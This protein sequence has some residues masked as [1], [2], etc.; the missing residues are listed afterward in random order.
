MNKPP[1]AWKNI[2]CLSLL[3]ATAKIGAQELSILGG[4]MTATQLEQSS[5]TW[6]VDYRQDFYRGLAGSVTYINEGHVDGHHRDGTAWQAWARLPFSHDRYALA[7]GAGIYYYYDT[8]MIAGESANVHGTAPIYGATFTGYFSDRWFYRL[9]AER[10]TPSH[11][12]KTTLAAAGAG[13]WFGRDRRPVGGKLGD[14]PAEKYYVTPPELTFFGGQSVVNTFF[15]EQAKAAALEFRRGLIPHVDWSLSGIYEGNP[16]V[17]RRNG[18][19]PQLWGVNTFYAERVSVGIGVG[20]YIYIDRKHPVPKSQRNPAALAPLVSLTFATR[21][22]ENWVARLNWDRVT[23]SY[24]RDA[25]IF[26][27]GLGYRWPRAQ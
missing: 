2:L 21:L 14:W 4:T 11:N 22:S 27:L 8:Q 7:I 20:P 15:S 5:Y 10:I 23:T 16:K 13:F 3:A 6:Q 24:N 26:L 9:S 25:D 12:L 17:V 18:V 1:R 19:A